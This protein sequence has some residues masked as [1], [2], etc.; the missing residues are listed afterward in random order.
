MHMFRDRV[1]AKQRLA[2]KL[3]LYADSKNTIVLG[4]PRGGVPIAFEIA[5]KLHLPLDILLVRKVEIPGQ[6]ELAMGAIATGGTRILDRV[7]IRQLGIT[8]E[9][10]ASAIADEEAEL[11][12][13]EQIYR[14]S[15][16]SVLIRDLQVIVVDDGIEIGRASC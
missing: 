4:L 12:R 13:R 5:Q 7:M 6:A 9:E 3:A 11:R 1:E 10:L 2:K 15:P 14:R 16:S 8:E